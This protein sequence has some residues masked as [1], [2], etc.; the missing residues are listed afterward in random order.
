M[1]ATELISDPIV[2]RN[3]VSAGAIMRLNDTLQRTSFRF[4]MVIDASEIKTVAIKKKQKGSDKQ[5]GQ[6]YVLKTRS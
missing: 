1:P 6:R 3:Y 4:H 2:L 5:L